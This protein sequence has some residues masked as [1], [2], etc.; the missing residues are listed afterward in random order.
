V[1]GLQER[2]NKVKLKILGPYAGSESDG[3]QPFTDRLHSTYNDLLLKEQAKP[4]KFNLHSRLIKSLIDQFGKIVVVGIATTPDTSLPLQAVLLRVAARSLASDE[5][6]MVVSSREMEHPLKS[7]YER[8]ADNKDGGHVFADY[9]FVSLNP[10]IRILFTSY[11]NVTLIHEQTVK[12]G[13][14]TS[15][16]VAD[17]PDDASLQILANL[18]LK[19]R[20]IA[21]WQETLKADEGVYNIDLPAKIII[22]KVKRKSINTLSVVKHFETTSGY[23]VAQLNEVFLKELG[24]SQKQIDAVMLLQEKGLDAE[25]KDFD[26]S[27]QQLIRFVIKN[28]K[29]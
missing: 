18:Q 9:H 29:R 1:V 8:Y 14:K 16:I 26:L 28:L 4:D 25:Y 20:L 2:F 22:E 17:R 19:K 24:F 7:V 10:L 23:S 13:R 21:V 3:L 27:T 12:A 6:V 5:L 15:L 11:N